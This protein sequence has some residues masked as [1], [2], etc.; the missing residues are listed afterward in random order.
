MA[1]ADSSN[2]ESGGYD[3]EFVSN[4]PDDVTCCVC[5]YVLKEPMQ[6]KECG[7]RF[8]RSCSDGLKRY[9]ISNLFF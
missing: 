1:S 8:C 9:Y 2:T 3:V 4:P 6:A 7:H 5:L